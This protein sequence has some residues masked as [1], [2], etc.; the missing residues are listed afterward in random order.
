MT[1]DYLIPLP[2]AIEA[3][4]RSGANQ[5]PRLGD[6][7]IWNIGEGGLIDGRPLRTRGIIQ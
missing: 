6:H 5:L 4:E 3:L 2:A 7:I 1:A